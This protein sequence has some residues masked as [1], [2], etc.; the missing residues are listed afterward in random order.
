MKQLN[1]LFLMILLSGNAPATAASNPDETDRKI[2]LALSAGNAEAL[3]AYFNTLIDL[4]VAGVEET[5]SKTQA[6]RILQDFFR[7]NPVKTYKVTRQG[8]S[9]DGSRFTIGT[10]EAGGKTYRVY[11]LLKVEGGSLLIHQLQIQADK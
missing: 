10:L 6:T 2:A 5:Y 9:N 11:Y 8:T 3:A 7:K 4:G 1:I